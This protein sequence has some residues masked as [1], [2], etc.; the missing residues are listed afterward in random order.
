M[1][2][3]VTSQKEQLLR[4][5]KQLKSDEALLK[6]QLDKTM[7]K[8][9]KHEELES[10]EVQLLLSNAKTKLEAIKYSCEKIN[11]IVIDEVC[12]CMHVFFNTRCR[13]RITIL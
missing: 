12:I 10:N 3:Q 1:S 5:L 2:I 13:C 6:D 8:Y 4:E 7:Q 11:L 9:K